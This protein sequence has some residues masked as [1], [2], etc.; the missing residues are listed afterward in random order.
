MHPQ[1]VVANL[2]GL[3]LVGFALYATDGRDRT[4][5][6]EN[7][8]L[9]AFA[10][11]SKSK[12]TTLE[13]ENAQLLA[14]LAKSSPQNINAVAPLGPAPIRTLKKKG[15]IPHV[16]QEEQ[17]RVG[18]EVGVFRGGFSNWMLSNWPACTR[19]Y[20]VDL[21][22]AQN[23]YRQMDNATTTKNLERMEEARRNVARFGSK[24]VLVR[25]SSVEAA[26][27]FDDASIDFVYLD[28][29]HTYDAVMEDL[30]AWWPKVR[31][32]GIVAGEDYMD[33]DEVWRMTA[34]CDF[35]GLG[36]GGFPWVGCDKWQLPYGQYFECKPR[37]ACVKLQLGSAEADAVQPPCGSDYSLQRDGT[38]RQDLK[39]VKGAV[40]DFARSKGRQLQIAHR[41]NQRAFMWEAW[42]MR[43]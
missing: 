26:A 33:A 11:A 39:A 29:R 25:K 12:A 37:P 34:T 9:R 14:Q 35:E 6:L 1:R 18:V 4:L 41:D 10:T 15:E 31:P 43:R 22:S 13:Q 16:L 3:G 32:G 17:L 40:D 30:E 42:L 20:M 8:K 38:R 7:A 28:A 27:Q 2:V 21:W 24:A 36:G 19:Y 23:N 5:V